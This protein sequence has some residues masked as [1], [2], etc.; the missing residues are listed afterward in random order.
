MQTTQ[1]GL[2][3]T[4]ICQ[5]ASALIEGDRPPAWLQVVKH[6]SNAYS[7]TP[8]SVTSANSPIWSVLSGLAQDSTPKSNSNSNSLTSA[9]QNLMSV[10]LPLASLLSGSSAK[11]SSSPDYTLSQNK[12]HQAQTFGSSFGSTTLSRLALA[13]WAS[14]AIASLVEYFVPSVFQTASRTFAKRKKPFDPQ[15]TFVDTPASVAAALSATNMNRQQQP[16][17]G[18]VGKQPPTPCPSV[19]EYISPTFARNYQGA[20]KYVVQIP[21]EGYF[22]QTIQRTSCVRQKCEFTEGVCHES[23][24][25]VSLLVAEIYYPNTVF[26]Q[27]AEAPVGSQSQMATAASNNHI[28]QVA[29]QQFQQQ[30][31]QPTPP[32]Q[33]QKSIQDP[34]QMTDSLNNYNHNLNNAFINAANEL[35]W[36]PNNVA[37]MQHLA[38]AYNYQLLSRNGLMPSQLQAA[39]SRSS[40]AS[41]PA[42]GPM[43]PVNPSNNQASNQYSSQSQSHQQLNAQTAYSNEYITALM[44]AALQ[45]NPNMN[46]NDLLNSLQLQQKRK[47]RDLSNQ[48]KR[49]LPSQ[50]VANQNS[51]SRPHQLESVASINDI[52]NHLQSQQLMPTN[53]LNPNQ[54]QA[55]KQPQA[56]S[57]TPVVEHQPSVN[58]QQVNGETGNQAQATSEGVNQVECDG[59]DKLGCYVVRVYYDWF[60][61]NG[62]CKCWKTGP[63][64]QAGSQTSNGNSFLRRIFTG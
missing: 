41:Y 32:L 9:K 23:P 64:S 56:E 60:L 22:T 38:N 34:L 8:D 3:M 54:M 62:S 63:T 20:W 53:S 57:S 25:W 15:E 12:E 7:G 49:P 42:G 11:D 10:I 35:G 28:Q 44:A 47:K 17:L 48:V 30:L 50:F 16:G 33:A 40:P 51:Q 5:V 58:A 2:S 18:L 1:I 59:H 36:D 46:I 45:Q 14:N 26:G 61:V 19:E 31:Q 43:Q 29:L 13:G 4:R 52:T 21:H 39:E 55:F 37:N 6:L 27:Q 24:R